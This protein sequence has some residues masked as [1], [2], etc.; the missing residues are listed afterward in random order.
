MKI[1]SNNIQN[2]NKKCHQCNKKPQKF[3]LKKC[4]KK[5]CFIYYCE[6][7]IK[8]YKEDFNVCYYCQ[9]ICKCKD[10]E[11]K[12][13]SKIKIENFSQKEI[14]EKNREIPNE[15]NSEL[16]DSLKNKNVVYIDDF[17]IIEEKDSQY[18]ISDIEDGKNSLNENDEE[19]VLGK[20]KIK[21]NNKQQEK[22]SKKNV[23]KSKRRKTN[24]SSLKEKAKEKEKEKNLIL[25]KIENE[26]EKIDLE[27]YVNNYNKF[28]NN[29]IQNLENTNTN[30]NLEKIN[31]SNIN[32][33]NSNINL[34]NK[35][36][37]IR[38]KRNSSSNLSEKI[39]L[40]PS[41]EKTYK[42]LSNPK[43]SKINS[44]YKKDISKP[45]EKIK[46]KIENY[47]NEKNRK[48]I[49]KYD[50]FKS[51][52]DLK[53]DLNKIKNTYSPIEPKE[54]NENIFKITGNNLPYFPI[55]IE[56]SNGNFNKKKKHGYKNCL[57]CKDDIPKYLPILRF[58]SSEEF[59]LYTS[60]FYERLSEDKISLY[61]E[62]KEYFKNY[63]NNYYK[64]CSQNNNFLFKS[65][66]FICLKCFE[67]NLIPENG[68]SNI[69]NN[70]QYGIN[71]NNSNVSNSLKS[72]IDNI[73]KP[74]RLEE[75]DL[76]V[77]KS[78]Q[79][80]EKGELSIY[81]NKEDNLSDVKLMKRKRKF[82]ISENGKILS[83][84]FFIFYM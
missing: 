37:I 20:N 24:Y 9:N 80:S 69:L 83:L 27:N 30:E 40:I 64:K 65:I 72:N 76:L 25:A 3:Q 51:E 13:C 21:S 12:I 59:V 81:E 58:K 15:E 75:N 36:Q 29:K 41:N 54:S 38:M 82:S 84:N 34:N 71:S 43:Y 70:L 17:M 79:N 2:K 60:Y 50:T 28:L 35:K 33:N 32:S 68:F 77:P 10:C 7:C 49:K 44:P 73:N 5:D 31:L 8:K 42:N 6:K 62:S 1:P 11:K 26:K 46:K 74:A 18:D 45:K 47:E 48:N 63:Y 19:F 23:K 61:K 14:S 78:N 67:K 55:N 4:C 57:F 56:M 39:N 52:K 53:N 22:I 66:K 16:N